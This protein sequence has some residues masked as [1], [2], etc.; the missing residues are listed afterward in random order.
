MEGRY[1]DAAL[2]FAG[3]ILSS[4]LFS[5]TAQQSSCNDADD[6][7]NAGNCK[8]DAAHAHPKSSW[9]QGDEQAVVGKRPGSCLEEQAVEGGEQ[10]VE[11]DGRPCSQRAKRREHQPAARHKRASERPPADAHRHVRKACDA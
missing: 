2:P 1:L 7:G 8:P 11:V 6:A 5:L 3:E 9:V 4:T 10:P